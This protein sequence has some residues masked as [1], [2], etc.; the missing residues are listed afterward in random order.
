MLM[1]LSGCWFLILA[2]DYAGS[3]NDA[4]RLAMVESLVDYRS[5]AIDHSRWVSTG[6]K[7]FVDGHFYSDKPPVIALGLASIYQLIQTLTGIS[8]HENESLVCWLLV[9]LGMG[10]PFLWAIWSIDTIGES[11][12]LRIADR[13]LI[14]FSLNFGTVLVA[15]SQFLNQ[16]FL[17]FCFL[18]ILLERVFS[19]MW[20][21]KE[22]YFKD[23]ILIGTCAGI[24]YGCDQAAGPS[25]VVALGIYGVL[26]QSWRRNLTIIIS[27]LPWLLLHHIV[28]YQIGGSFAPANS[29][30]DYLKWPGSA[31][32]V[33]NMTGVIPDRSVG[34]LIGYGFEMLIGKKGF[35]GHNP[36]LYLAVVGWVLLRKASQN[37]PLNRFLEMIAIWT[38]MTFVAYLLFSNNASGACLSVRWFVP[39]LAPGYIV[40]MLL[41]ANLP[42]VRPV[43]IILTVTGFLL[44]LSMVLRGPWTQRMLPGYWIIQGIGLAAACVTWYKISASLSTRNLRVVH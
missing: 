39:F 21:P 13:L 1:I 33:G 28:N 16:H 4:S 40:L 5:L 10:P 25:L 12:G 8:F 34:V 7:L 35:I 37:P 38:G 15:Y 24:L 41:L 23:S 9:V 43:L 3:W 17:F 32:H 19:A 36:T 30:P 26:T 29:N 42:A 18:T 14:W 31:F 11:L 2:R 27:A 6:D 20:E 44:G 22:K